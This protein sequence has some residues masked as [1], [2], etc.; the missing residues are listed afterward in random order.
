MLEFQIPRSQ[1]RAFSALARLD[2]AAR[3]RLFDALKGEPLTVK[4]GEFAE[5]FAEATGIP[6][7]AAKGI[8]WMLHHMYSARASAGLSAAEFA[9]GICRGVTSSTA[10]DLRKLEPAMVD[11]VQAF[12]ARVL[13]LDDSLGVVAKGISVLQE[14]ER[15]FSECRVLT[16][17]RPIFREN[18]DETPSAGVIVH[19]L[20]ISYSEGGSTKAFFVTLDGSD[21]ADLK[22]CIERAQ[23]KEAGLKGIVFGSIPCLS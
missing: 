16:D 21:L 7:I 15:L 2:D 23:S 22:S 10:L 3:D 11:T 4:I 8:F 14:N 17:F 13:A 1:H 5:R 9:E 18:L 12:L 20:R 19:Q 6:G